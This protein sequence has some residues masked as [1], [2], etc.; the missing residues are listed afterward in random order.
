LLKKYHRTPIDPPNAAF[1]DGDT[2]W[3]PILNV[4]IGRTRAKPSVRFLAV[5]DTGSPYCLFSADIGRSVGLHIESGSVHYLTGVVA[6]AIL[7]AFFHR[8]NLIVE[9]NWTIE[10]TAGFS[11]QFGAG[12]LLGRRG[13]FDHFTVRFDHSTPTPSFEIERLLRPS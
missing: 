1:K 11:D 4:R 12:A 7:P 3:L 9:D 5:V 6:G 10:V 8:V 13:F 2:E